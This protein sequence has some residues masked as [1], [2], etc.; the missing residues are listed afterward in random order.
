MTIA[1]WAMPGRTWGGMC[2]G[3]TCAGGDTS[4]HYV[5]NFTDI[6]DKILNRAK[7]EGTTMAAISE[8]YIQR[9]FEDM[10]RLKVMDARRVFPE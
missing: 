5:Q 9:Y 4:V 3:A 8:R 10:H 7:A 2:C 6:D 1:I